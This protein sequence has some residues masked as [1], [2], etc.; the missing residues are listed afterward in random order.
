MPPHLIVSSAKSS[1][2]LKVFRNCCVVAICMDAAV[3]LESS[4]ILRVIYI[5]LRCKRDLLVV[6]L[7]ETS[8]LLVLLRTASDLEK[9]RRI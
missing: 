8:H 5:I 7:R 6:I 4:F 9:P 2:W 1:A 3:K